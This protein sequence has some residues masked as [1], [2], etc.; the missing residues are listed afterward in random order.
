MSGG[1]MAN[2]IGICERHMGLHRLEVISPGPDHMRTRAVPGPQP[3][4]PIDHGVHHLLRPLSVCVRHLVCG[5]VLPAGKGARLRHIAPSV[6]GPPG[7]MASPARCSPWRDLTAAESACPAGGETPASAAPAL[8]HV[9]RPKSQSTGR[10]NQKA[11]QGC[12]CLPAGL[13]QQPG[14]RACPGAKATSDQMTS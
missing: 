12:F 8:A 7:G 13:N 14:G 5:D 10:P 6:E 11:Q 9:L 2:P 4:C 3:T 1:G